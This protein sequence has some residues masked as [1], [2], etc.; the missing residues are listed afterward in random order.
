MRPNDM[1]AFAVL[2]AADNWVTAIEI[3]VAARQ[4]SKEIEAEQEAVDLTETRLA[5]AVKKWRSQRF[6]RE[7]LA[8]D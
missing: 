4:A 1:E 6:E 3:L 2:E 8:A 5:M 7:Q